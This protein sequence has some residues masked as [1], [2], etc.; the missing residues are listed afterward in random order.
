[1]RLSALLLAL[2]ACGG[3][4]PAA[5]P[6]LASSSVTITVAPT[7][8]DATPAPAPPP[9]VASAA[10]IAVP[11]RPTSLPGTSIRFTGGD[12]TSIVTAIKIK[13]AKG[14]MDGTASEYSYLALV[15]GPANTAW[16]MG[17]QSLLTDSGKNYDALA[18][19]LAD[20]TKATVYFDISDYFG[21][22]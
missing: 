10:P 19:T 12:G 7:P 6:P 14:E 18:I 22:Y 11:K 9:P 13:G 17:Q 3:A 1:M 4:T 16:T 8:P 15:Y 5:Q 2:V 20:G 21:K